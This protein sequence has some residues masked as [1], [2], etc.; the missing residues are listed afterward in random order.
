MHLAAAASGRM[1][2]EAGL[3]AIRGVLVSVC[4]ATARILVNVSG[5]ARGNLLRS[6]QDDRAHRRA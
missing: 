6:I 4:A 5:Q 2:L 3:R 1:S